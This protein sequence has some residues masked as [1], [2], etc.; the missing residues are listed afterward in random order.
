MNNEE[1][2]SV[3]KRYGRVQHINTEVRYYNKTVS[4]LLRENTVR[5]HM[6]TNLLMRQEINETRQCTVWSPMQVLVML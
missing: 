4:F 6:K 3:C 1:K 5:I 2:N